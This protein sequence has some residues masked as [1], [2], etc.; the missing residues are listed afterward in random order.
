VSRRDRAW[1]WAV[2]LPAFSCSHAPVV[3][4]PDATANAADSAARAGHRVS[5][6]GP[7]IH[8][9]AG[10]APSPAPPAAAGG[11]ACSADTDCGYDPAFDRCGTDPRY[12]R[13]PPIVDQ[14]ILCYC[15][16][17]SHACALLKVPPVPCESDA[18]C[19]VRH[20][21]RPHPVRADRDN[22]RER[23]RPCLNLTLSTTCERTNICTLHRHECPGR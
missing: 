10:G 22:P 8:H 5:A 17:P 4:S 7:P 6:T 19:A 12:N 11:F 1:L 18:D 3:P 14:G 23:G 13:Q 15:D 9:A 21:P 16:P 2:V 20:S